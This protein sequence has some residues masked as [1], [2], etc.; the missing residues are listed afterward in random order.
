MTANVLVQTC[1][2]LC[3]L[4]MLNSD[5]NAWLV[6]THSSQVLVDCSQALGKILNIS[7]GVSLF[8]LYLY[9]RIFDVFNLSVFSPA[10]LDG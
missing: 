8:V 10:V 6:T 2:A 1:N 9:E 7:F 4:V 5:I 3:R